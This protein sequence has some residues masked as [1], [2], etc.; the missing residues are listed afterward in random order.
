VRRIGVVALGALGVVMLLAPA[1]SAHALYRRSDPASGAVL[2]SPPR[3]VTITYTEPPDP[4][5]ASVQVVSATGARLDAGPATIIPGHPTQLQVPLK[6][7]GDGVY[8]VTWRVVSKADGHTTVGSFS[9]GVGVSSRD[10]RAAAGR[11]A[12]LRSPPAPPAAVAGRW[13][14]YWGLAIPFAAGVVGMVVFGGEV[15]M[16]R[17]LLP[18][19]WCLAAIGLVVLTAADA[20][21]AGVSVGALLGSST[22]VAL[23]REGAAL[24]VTGASAT[25]FLMRRSRVG[26]RAVM[27]TGAL[28]ILM[29]AL[30]GHAEAA[31][32]AWF[33]VG[34]QWLHMMAVGAWI[35]GLVLLVGWIRGREGEERAAGVRRF[36]WLAAILL[37]V[38]AATGLLREIDEVGG[39]VQWARLVT[40]A[41]GIVVLVK[42]GLFAPLLAI[43]WR[44]RTVN[45][46]GM[47]KE[48]SRVSSLRRAV[49]GELA[50]ATAIF[51]ATGLLTELAPSATVAAASETR[52]P[53]APRPLVVMG[54]DFATSVRV[55]LTVTPGTIGPNLFRAQIVDFDTGR[56][57][58]A[59]AV[60]LQLSLPGNPEVGS[61]TVDLRRA[62]RGIWTARSTVLSLNGRWDADLLVQKPVGGV[63]VLMHLLPRLPREDVQVARASGQP[64]VYTV[65]LSGGATLQGYV[66]PGSAGVN[67]VH[68]TFFTASGDEQPISSA[69]ASAL[70]PSGRSRPLKLIRFDSGHFV[71]N[72]AL[73]AGRW[74]FLIEAMAKQGPTYKAYFSPQVEANQEDP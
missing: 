61:P 39:P 29:H 54:N 11:A 27:A 28:T 26:L 44:N 2:S 35:G 22:G 36:S 16:A 33:N 52:S 45:V 6:P 10:V 9:F 62:G 69:S 4:K 67:A 59:D 48:P 58:A 43:A 49:V 55:R 74:T 17:I 18:A 30:G 72:A 51:A 38:V 60:E 57:V 13:A 71:S 1:A 64:T 68:F 25:F 14:I 21:T 65:S 20:S 5:L 73:D 42:V 70:T 50:I 8:T 41:Y 40:T 7:L 56:P 63:E 31:S 46:P 15:P 34:I 47:S 66:D 3:R 32:P 23:I 53:P 24:L 19:A 12:K 37:A